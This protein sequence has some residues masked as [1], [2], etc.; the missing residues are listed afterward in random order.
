[1]ETRNAIAWSAEFKEPLV[2]GEDLL[3]TLFVSKADGNLAL[4]ADLSSHVDVYQHRNEVDQEYDYFFLTH[5]TQV[6]AY[7]ESQV[8]RI[9]IVHDKPFDD[10]KLLEY[11]PFSQ[12]GNTFDAMIYRDLHWSYG[13]Q[14]PT[15]L[16]ADY[17][18]SADRVSW[19]VTSRWWKRGLGSKSLVVP[20]SFWASKGSYLGVDVTQRAQIGYQFNKYWMGIPR[21]VRY[22]YETGYV[23]P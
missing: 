1:M 23:Q 9:E 7:N 22:D 18:M 19:T 11:G 4:V 6:T 10:V 20:G 12:K 13:N 2:L 16:K 8:K 14:Q 17:V 15:E 5:G 3:C 21:A